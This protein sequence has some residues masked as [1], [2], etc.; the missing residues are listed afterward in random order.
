MSVCGTV[1]F[2]DLSI[3]SAILVCYF[4]AEGKKVRTLL[5]LPYLFKVTTVAKKRN[6]QFRPSRAEVADALLFQVGV[7]DCNICC[8]HGHFIYKEIYLNNQNICSLNISAEF[9]CPDNP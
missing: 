6:K 5:A 3:N 8:L 9:R 4:S 7:C 1:T 2:M